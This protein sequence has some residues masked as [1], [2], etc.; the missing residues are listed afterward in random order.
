[1]LT[2]SSCAAREISPCCSCRTSPVRRRSFAHVHLVQNCPVHWGSCVNVE[3][4]HE[5]GV[6][7]DHRMSSEWSSFW[8]L[9][10]TNFQ[11]ASLDS[12]PPLN[13]GA[14]GC[15]LSYLTHCLSIL[16][17]PSTC[18][19][20]LFTFGHTVNSVWNNINHL[21]LAGVCMYTL[22]GSGQP[23]LLSLRSCL[24]CFFE[25][26]SL[27]WLTGDLFGSSYPVVPTLGIHMYPMP[28]GILWECR[29][30]NLV[31]VPHGKPFIG[32]TISPIL[33][34]CLLKMFVCKHWSLGVCIFF[35]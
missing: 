26:G 7:W 19:G 22:E 18:Y 28:P 2:L 14:V 25:M 11:M 34:R 32:W 31:L 4:I 24:P 13:Q 30:E 35:F 3:N 21:F 9:C 10:I 6:V 33:K 29:D 5:Y 16:V 15:L 17:I 12:C 8:I 20:L 1:M 27:D 23:Q